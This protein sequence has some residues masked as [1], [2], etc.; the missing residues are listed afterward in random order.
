MQECDV[1]RRRPQRSHLRMTCADGGFNSACG[2]RATRMR[3][4]S[5]LHRAGHGGRS[6]TIEQDQSLSSACGS[7]GAT[8]ALHRARHWLDSPFC[9]AGTPF[10]RTP[11]ARHRGEPITSKIESVVERNPDVRAAAEFV[12]QAN[13]KGADFDALNA[14]RGEG[15][16]PASGRSS[17]ARGRCGTSRSRSTLDES[18]APFY[19]WFDDGELNVSY[20][21]LD[22]NLENGNAEQGRRSS[23]RPTTAPSPRSPTATSISASAA[24]PT[25]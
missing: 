18:N 13:V 9:A 7:S 10:A 21:C 14:E 11:F 2:R 23:S 16:R 8:A 3:C 4:G 24:S 22:R 6:Q 15:F 5:G 1:G 19:K 17:R 12:A 20:N 25:G